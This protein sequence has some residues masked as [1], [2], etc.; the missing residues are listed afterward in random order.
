VKPNDAREARVLAWVKQ[1]YTAWKQWP[2]WLWIMIMRSTINQIEVAQ[3][4]IYMAHYQHVGHAQTLQLLSAA[5]VVNGQPRGSFNGVPKLAPPVRM[6][7][8]RMANLLNI[9]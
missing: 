7:I 8:V 4:V 9:S 3:A 1:K 5:D 6:T 2:V